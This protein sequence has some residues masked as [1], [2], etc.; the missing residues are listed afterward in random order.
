MD[1]QWYLFHSLAPATEFC[2]E[3]RDGAVS[4]CFFSPHCITHAHVPAPR[5]HTHTPALGTLGYR[6]VGALWQIIPARKNSV[7][8]PH[9][10]VGG[11]LGSRPRKGSTASWFM[12]RWERLAQEQWRFRKTPLCSGETRRGF[13]SGPSLVPLPRPANHNSHMAFSG[14]SLSSERFGRAQH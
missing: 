1:G 12:L 7:L 9:R 4:L 5:A 6:W 2:L 10:P 11:T 14:T 13:P 8:P 3:S